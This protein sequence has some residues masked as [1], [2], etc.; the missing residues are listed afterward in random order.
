MAIYTTAMAL[1]FAGGPIILSLVTEGSAPYLLGACI[2][3]GAMVALLN[4]WVTVPSAVHPPTNRPLAYLTL[5]PISLSA[6]LLNA[7]I[8]TAGL[9]FI[10]LYAVDMEWSEAS[11]MR[12]LSTLMIGA[13]LLQVPIGWLADRF[14]RRRL[15]IVLAALSAIGALVWPWL[16]AHPWMAYALI[17]MWGGVFVGIY[18]VMLALVGSRFKGGDLVRMYAVMSVMWG[19][20]ALIGP[21]VV[22][23]AMQLSPRFGLPY[24]IAMACGTFAFVAAWR[25]TTT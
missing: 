3:L 25:R 23:V 11:G 6:T 15:M 9:S 12:L 8:E 14:D 24:T 7:S 4:P 1:G 10:A 16:F 18:T 22:G 5:A 21:T 19:V 20:G 13:I 2:T 17:F